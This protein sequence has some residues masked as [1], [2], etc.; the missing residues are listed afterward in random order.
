MSIGSYVV[1][2]RWR[3]L[4]GS[5]LEITFSLAL[6]LDSNHISTAT[7]TF[8]ESSISVKLHTILFNVSE[9]RKN[10]MINVFKKCHY[11]QWNDCRQ[12]TEFMKNNAELPMKSVVRLSQQRCIIK[13]HQIFATFHHFGAAIYMTTRRHQ[14]FI[15]QNRNTTSMSIQ[16]KKTF[17]P[18]WNNRWVQSRMSLML[19]GMV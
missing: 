6:I 13:T 12:S 9:S 11:W 18:N 4:T 17:R 14:S 1:N 15:E 10:W 19:A 2:Q 16:S 7:T 5:R 3:P 8:T